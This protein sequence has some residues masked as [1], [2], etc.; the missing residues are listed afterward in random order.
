MIDNEPPPR[1]IKDTEIFT[2][3]SKGRHN[4]YCITIDIRG[5][6]IDMV[7]GVGKLGSGVI[8]KSHYLM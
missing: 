2:F 4:M 3:E 1:A 8:R 6:K 5:Y 7:V